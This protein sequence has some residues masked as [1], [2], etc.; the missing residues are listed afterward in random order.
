MPINRL[1]K[2]A[3]KSRLSSLKNLLKT[4]EIDYFIL[5]NCDEF[6]SEYLPENEK[7]IEYLTGFTGSNALI[8]FGQKK[9]YFFTDG[10]YILQAKNE[11]DLQEFEIINMAEKPVISWLEEN[12]KKN[13]NLAIDPK[14]SSLNFVKNCQKV[15]AKTNVNLILLDGN[16]VDKIWKN[17]SH[18]TTSEIFLNP[19][20]L[21]GLDSLTKRQK[22]IANCA[23]DFLVITDPQ[24]LCWLLNIRASDVEYTPLLLAYGILFKNGEV[25]LFVDEKRINKEA[26]SQLKKVN[27]VQS[28][29][30]DLR[31]NVLHKSYRKVQI[32]STSTNY[33]LY[34]LLLKNNFEINLEQDPC[35]L[36]KACKNSS[37]ISGMIK[38]HEVDG[39]AVTKFLFWLENSLENDELKSEKKLLEFRKESADFLYPSFRSISGFASNGAIIHYHSEEKTNKKFTKNS[40][41]LID[42]GGQYFAKDKVNNFAG[43]TDITRTVAIGSPS[44]EMIE[45]F[46]R[47]LK[48]HIALARARFPVGTTGAQLDVLARFHLWQANKDYDHGT[49]HGVGSFLSVHEGPCSISKRSHQPLLEGMI[50][51]NEPGFYKEGEYGIRIESLML[52]EKSKKKNFLQFKILTLTPID[53]HLIDFRMLTSRERKWLREYHARI[54]ESLKDSLSSNESAWLEEIVKSYFNRSN[55]ILRR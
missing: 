32:D 33:W 23:W 16:L 31:I 10:R 27:F 13:A 46:T 17:K 50:L 2:D 53:Y 42:S 1:M 48:G 4:D 43:T 7:R 25:D 49:G 12:L 52:V 36:L 26:K 29:C 24:S 47:V 51:S 41:Y 54:F 39:L 21:S 28:D 5:P 9:S 19:L 30:L 44:E 6:F 3:F 14:L 20:S 35:L 34:Q 55:K 8:I 37:E 45:D 11:I 22:I 40:L 15:C 38:S 18:K